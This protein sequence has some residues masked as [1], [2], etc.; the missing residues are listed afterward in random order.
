MKYKIVCKCSVKSDLLFSNVI[1]VSCFVVLNAQ[2]GSCGEL[3][4]LCLELHTFFTE[5]AKYDY[6]G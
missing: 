4:R 3:V 6:F 2:T 5:F 1:Y